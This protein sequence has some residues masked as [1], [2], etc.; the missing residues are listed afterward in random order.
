MSDTLVNRYTGFDVAQGDERLSAFLP[1]AERGQQASVDLFKPTLTDAG[2]TISC[3]LHVG[4]TSACRSLASLLMWRSRTPCTDR[5]REA[6][7][8]RTGAL[9]DLD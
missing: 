2:S 9:V 5:Q 8:F 6:V 7:T 4:S 3:G 1:L